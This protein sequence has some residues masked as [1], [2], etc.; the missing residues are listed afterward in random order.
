MLLQSTLMPS[1]SRSNTRAAS[2]KPSVYL[3]REFASRV[4]EGKV[5]LT[6]VIQQPMVW[7]IGDEHGLT[8]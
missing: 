6:R 1:E 5:L 3:S 2:A 7:L 4:H 8:D